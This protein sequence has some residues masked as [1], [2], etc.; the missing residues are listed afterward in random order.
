MNEFDNFNG[1]LV[2]KGEKLFNTGNRSF[3]YGDGL[4]ETIKV[5]D[6]KLMYWDDHYNRLK[7]GIDLLRLDDSN[8]SKAKWEQELERIVYRNHY[9]YESVENYLS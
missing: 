8:M 7:K 2:E 6:G 1:F 9:Q 3:K 5:V 4:F